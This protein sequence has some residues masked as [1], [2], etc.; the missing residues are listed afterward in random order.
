MVLAGVSLE[1]VPMRLSLLSITL[2][3]VR[4]YLTRVYHGHI[5]LATKRQI[6]ALK[7]FPPLRKN[8]TEPSYVIIS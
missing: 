6:T 8:P 4:H 5:A 1:E 2:Q 7:S 3:L